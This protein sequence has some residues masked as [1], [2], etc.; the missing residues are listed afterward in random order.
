[1]TREDYTKILNRFVVKNYEK[2]SQKLN[3]ARRL[4]TEEDAQDWAE[5][6]TKLKMDEK[7]LYCPAV[8]EKERAKLYKEALNTMTAFKN[9]AASSKRKPAL[10][11]TAW[12]FNRYCKNY[13]I[14]VN[15]NDAEF[16]ICND[17]GKTL[18]LKSTE[19][20]KKEL[21]AEEEKARAFSEKLAEITTNG[22]GFISLNF[23]LAEILS[24]DEAGIEEYEAER[25]DGAYS[26]EEEAALENHFEDFETMTEDHEKWLIKRRAERYLSDRD[27]AREDFRAAC[28][29]PEDLKMTIVHPYE[30]D[31]FFKSFEE[32]DSF[33]DAELAVV[34][35][36]YKVLIVKKRW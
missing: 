7:H 10:I 9:A 6:V 8:F 19:A 34:N 1:M 23:T 11:L 2:T 17:A 27:A 36:N 4:K 26:K 32:A 12:D 20:H 3:L 21:E 25:F 5:R 13:E 16:F 14:A 18:F 35:E 28:G 22:D 24:E 30:E 33:E 29:L 31:Q 15:K